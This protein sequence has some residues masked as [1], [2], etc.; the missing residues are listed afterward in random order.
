MDSKKHLEIQEQAKQIMKKFS[1]SLQKIKLVK[2]EEEESS[3][4]FR[5]ELDGETADKEFRERFFK[6]APETD[7]DFL[8][9]EKKIW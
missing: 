1:S 5:E 4:G 6:N 8:V 2:V 7:G 9:A 3:G